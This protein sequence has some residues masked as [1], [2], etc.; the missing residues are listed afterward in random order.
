LFVVC[1]FF[2]SFESL[3]NLGIP[4]EKKTF[5]G[6]ELITGPPIVVTTIV[7]TAVR[8]AQFPGGEPGEDQHRVVVVQR[9]Q[10]GRIVQPPSPRGRQ[11]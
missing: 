6:M 11:R 9:Q 4:P 8:H 2:L 10:R 1:L 5:G 7:L 3:K